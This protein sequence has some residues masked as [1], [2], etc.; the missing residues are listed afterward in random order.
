MESTI[1]LHQAAVLL[2]ALGNSKR[3]EIVLL[4]LNGERNVGV[5]AQAMGMSN[6]A[7]SQHLKKLRDAEIVGSRRESQVI[8]YSL[9]MRSVTRL[10]YALA[11]PVEPPAGNEVD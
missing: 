5:L 7:L 3:L 8:F 1:E 6:S 11:M 9:R 10:I 2:K 4:L